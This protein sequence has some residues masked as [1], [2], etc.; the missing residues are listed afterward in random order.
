M[1]VEFNQYVSGILSSHNIPVNLLCD[2]FFSNFCIANLPWSYQSVGFNF[3]SFC[4]F[5][6]VCKQY[7]FTCISLDL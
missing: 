2:F 5:F 1:L 6:P 4:F 7:F 3:A